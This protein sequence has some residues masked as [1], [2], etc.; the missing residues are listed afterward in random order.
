VKREVDSQIKQMLH[1]NTETEAK[2]GDP[3]FNDSDL[4]MAGYAAALVPVG[5]VERSWVV[6]TLRSAREESI[7]ISTASDMRGLPPEAEVALGVI[8]GRW[9]R[10]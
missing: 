1:L 5:T 3:V 2:M 8:L 10:G 7:E 6:T 4:Q 9:N